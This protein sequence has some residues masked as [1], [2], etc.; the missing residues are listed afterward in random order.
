ME[1]S[2]EKVLVVFSLPPAHFRPV[3]RN[4]DVRQSY[5][6]RNR[7]ALADARNVQLR[8]LTSI[9]ELRACIPS[10]SAQSR[11]QSQTTLPHVAHDHTF[12]SPRKTTMRI[13]FFSPV[14][15]PNADRRPLR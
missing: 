10:Q 5:S 1:T 8:R 13:S 9:L 3:I 14:E 2:S 11:Q 6:L 7:P 12:S 4:G 15:H